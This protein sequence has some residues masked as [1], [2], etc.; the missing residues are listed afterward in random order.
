V[1]VRSP[2]QLL[3]MFYFNRLATIWTLA[4][5][6]LTVLPPLEARTRKGDKLLVQGR[7]RELR[8]ELGRRHQALPAGSQRVPR[9]RGYQLAVNRARF[10]AGQMHMDKGLAL[11]AQGRLGEADRLQMDT[12]YLPVLERP[13]ALRRATSPRIPTSPLCSPRPSRGRTN[14]R[15]GAHDCKVGED[16]RLLQTH[17]RFR[18]TEN[19]RTLCV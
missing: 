15:Q 8:K 3:K 5:M 4:A 17:R 19:L 18:L 6:A 7:S 13:S 2:R 16:G 9:R 1:P 11:R 12:D 14:D 10:Q